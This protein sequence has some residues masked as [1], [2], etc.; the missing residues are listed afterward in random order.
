MKRFKISN[1]FC[2]MTAIIMAISP[3]VFSGAVV[4]ASEVSKNS[5]SI[6]TSSKAATSV[7]LESETIYQDENGS[8]FT[9]SEIIVQSS[10]FDPRL[11]P[12]SSA[13]VISIGI[14]WTYTSKADGT[15]LKNAF[16]KA[17][18]AEGILGIT[19]A[20]AA[21]GIETGP[22]A[23]ILAVI[24]GLGALAFSKRFTEGANLI[25]SHPNSGKIYMYLDHCTYKK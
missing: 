15:K 9:K 1:F 19:A 23:A 5:S 14:L 20:I 13:S 10:P 22:I 24:A 25:A 12:F 6:M 21:A 17:A 4:H 16:R 8:V 18:T 11:Q 7:L 3:F 2:Y